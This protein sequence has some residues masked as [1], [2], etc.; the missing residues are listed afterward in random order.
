MLQVD[1]RCPKLSIR[2]ETLIRTIHSR[3]DCIASGE[4][5]VE[6]D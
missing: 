3:K 6:Q 2:E 4:L 1:A 5:E